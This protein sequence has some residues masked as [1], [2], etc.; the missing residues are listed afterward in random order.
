MS[1]TTELRTLGCAI[2]GCLCSANLLVDTHV[3]SLWRFSAA[4]S[5]PSSDVG[6]TSVRAK[7]R[8]TASRLA[9]LDWS[10]H[11]GPQ[12]QSKSAVDTSPP[13]GKRRLPWR[14]S[15]TRES[16]RDRRASGCCCI[17]AF[18]LLQNAVAAHHFCKSIGARRPCTRQQS[19]LN[20][21]PPRS[22]STLQKPSSSPQH[23][24]Q[25]HP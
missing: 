24:L 22:T 5:Q 16:E 14:S 20:A 7:R 3:F 25:P 13:T 4:L 21:A 9:H 1:T 23:Q 15:P 18:W 17:T 6:M 12:A 8:I 19:T 2:W 11:L 10:Q